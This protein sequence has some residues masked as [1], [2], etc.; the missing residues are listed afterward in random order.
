[1][2]KKTFITTLILLIFNSV[3]AQQEL[4][5]RVTRQAV[6]IDSLK[7][8]IKS[9]EENS[10]KLQD[11]IEKL[12]VDLVKLN[13]INSEKNKIDKQLLQKSDSIAVLLQ[14]VSE[15][16]NQVIEA[17]KSGRNEVS[18]SVQ[19]YY[20]NK[21][22]DDLVLLSTAQSA[23]NDL[24]L[25]TD[26]ELKPLLTDLNNYHKAKKVLENRYNA[27]DIK[28]AQNLLSQIKQQSKQLENLKELVDN[29]QMFN[30]GLKEM[31]NK[32][33]ALDKEDQ[34]FGAPDIVQKGKLYKISLYIFNYDFNLKDYPYLSDIVLEIIKRKQPNPDADISDLLQK[35]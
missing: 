24:Q 10:Q 21:S 18:K 8:I 27:T 28:N 15:K 17:K 9:K 6:E 31:I 1:M 3:V 2:M 13:N 20:K 12:K 14:T 23:Q 25:L 11:S 22:F 5:D 7:R 35:L 30:D 33:I 19:N 32:I 4:I 34:V 16:E 26:S 29:Y